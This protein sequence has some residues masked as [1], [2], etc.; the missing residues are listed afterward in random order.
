MCEV[1]AVTVAERPTRIIVVAFALVLAWIS[2]LVADDLVAGTVT[3]ATA[4]WLVLGC[5]GLVQ[6]FGAVRRALG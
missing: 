3:V 2:G 5:F 1:G 4:V 6:L